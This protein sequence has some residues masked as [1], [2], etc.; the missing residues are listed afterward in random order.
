MRRRRQTTLIISFCLGVLGGLGLSR[1]L[2]V[3]PQVWWLG[4][5]PL[6]LLL[7]RKNI[8]SLIIIT[9]CGLL[10]G[11]SRGGAFME[12]A[13]ALQNLN[14]QKVVVTG[15]ALTD[16]IY[17]QN[18]QIEFDLGN[19][20]LE[21]SSN[22]P[23]AGRFKIGGFGEPMVYRGDIVQVEGKLFLTRGSRQARITYA[24]LDRVGASTFWLDSLRRHYATGMYNAL[25]EPAAS[26][27]LG[28]LIGQR[29]TLPQDVVNQLALVGLV[30]IVAVSG[31]NVTILS[32][33]VAR[34]RLPSKFQK[35]VLS[36][37]LIGMFVLVTG[38]SA[39]IVRAAL[40]S[41]LSLWAWYYGRKL[42]PLLLIL[43]VAAL[44]GLFNPFYVWS[45]IGWYLSFLAFA[46]VLIVAPLIV[47][48][49]FSAKRKPKML[50]MVLIETVS[51]QLM[52][53]PLIAMIFGQVSIISI[54]ANAL[55]V[56]LVPV[57]MLLA[58]IAAAAGVWLTAFAGWLAWPAK[59]LLTYMLDVTQLLSTVPAAAISITFS[60]AGM[61]ICY[62][63]L[64]IVFIAMYRRVKA[65][66]DILTP[67]QK[68]E[69]PQSDYRLLRS[70]FGK[71][72]AD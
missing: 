46:G 51:A 55:V 4:F 65:K 43:L 58:A 22:Q 39:S 69:A 1:R 27:G 25:P 42:K 36:L 21:E 30:H 70:G 5:L 40:V 45:D 15:T 31:Y 3:E 72:R 17:G 11:L 44:T 38:F 12:K 26:F 33:A 35:L 37:L 19:I 59:L 56:P 9:I 7:R 28:L 66:T 23:L 49:F 47:K 18:S 67:H 20:I 52:T 6:L 24:K 62:G 48:R 14:G 61:V 13:S 53:M 71:G 10:I 16:S 50:G 57:A 68:L 41:L 8:T 29:S 54:L 60:V 63:V 64:G 2:I 32:R 34:L